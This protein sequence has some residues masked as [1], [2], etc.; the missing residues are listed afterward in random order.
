M[1]RSEKNNFVQKLKDELS[2]SSSV[3]VAHYSGLSV[4]E[5]DSLRKEMR[6]NGAKFKVTKNRL[7]KIALANTPYE[8]IIDLFV[9]PTAIAYSS[10]PVAPAKVSVNFEKKFKSFII[11][12]GS[13]KGEKIDQERIK[14]LASLPSLEEIRLKLIRLLLAPAQKITS[15]L[16]APAG[17]LIRLLES[18]SKKKS[19]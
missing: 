15:V 11:L 12:G 2:G 7:T 13:F 14:F 4:L 9:G 17:Q 19:N 8:S 5:S 1:K 18:H 3:I 10:D 16:Q 6:D